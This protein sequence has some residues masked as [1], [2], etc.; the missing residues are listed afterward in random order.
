MV[1]PETRKIPNWLKSTLLDAKGHGALKG[2]F[3]ES[4]KSK[5]YYEYAAYMTKQIE[6]EPSTVEDAVNHQKWKDAMNEEY[7]SIIKNGV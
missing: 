4:K 1:I 7:Q 5:R 6:A 2:S 3:R